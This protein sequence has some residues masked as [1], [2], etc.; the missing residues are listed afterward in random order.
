MATATP[1]QQ[2]TA[3]RILREHGATD[4]ERTD[5]TIV[6]GNWIDFDPLRPVRPAAG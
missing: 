2:E 1:V 6:A 4:T 3:I 5:G